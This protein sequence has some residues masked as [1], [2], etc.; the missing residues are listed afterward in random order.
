MGTFSLPPYAKIL[1][2]EIVIFAL[3]ITEGHAVYAIKYLSTL[4]DTNRPLFMNFLRHSSHIACTLIL[5]LYWVLWWVTCFF[6]EAEFSSKKERKC[7]RLLTFLAFSS[8]V[9]R[10]GASWAIAK[11]NESF[12]CGTGRHAV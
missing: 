1:L 6:C 12:R 5:C 11:E 2:S 7:H 8:L 3:A 10:R 4:L 9:A